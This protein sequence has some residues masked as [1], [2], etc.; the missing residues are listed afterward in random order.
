MVSQNETLIIP[1]FEYDNICPK[2]TLLYYAG[3]F[4]FDAVKSRWSNIYISGLHGVSF[5]E[6]ECRHGLNAAS[7][8]P[9][10]F[11]KVSVLQIVK[12]NMTLTETLMMYY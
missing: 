5:S 9:S 8:G 10:L 3:T 7:C 1:C 6:R 12:I 11:V 2:S 4:Y